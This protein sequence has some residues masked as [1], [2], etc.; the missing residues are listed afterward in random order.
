M[1]RTENYTRGVGN[2]GNRTGRKR[3]MKDK[4]N[5]D[6]REFFEQVKSDLEKRLEELER[7]LSEGEKTARRTSME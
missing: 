3:Q 1:Q 4:N 5:L 7:R 6:G 2:G